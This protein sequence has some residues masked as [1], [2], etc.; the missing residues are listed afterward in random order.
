[1]VAVI[2]LLY[3]GSGRLF[4]VTMTVGTLVLFAEYTRRVF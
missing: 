2:L 4:G 3:L 1:V